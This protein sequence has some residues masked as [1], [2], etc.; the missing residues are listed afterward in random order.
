MSK[1][2]LEIADTSPCFFCT[3]DMLLNKSTCAYCGK[4]APIRLT[5]V[6]FM[7]AFFEGHIID[8]RAGGLVL[9]RHDNEEDIP[10]YSAVA[11]GV[12]QLC[13]VMQGGEYVINKEATAKHFARIEEINDY[14][15]STY[16]PIESI[17]ITNKTRVFNS[18][19]IKGNMAV[20]LDT[21]QYIIN[22]AATIK[23]YLELEEINNSVDHKVD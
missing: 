21:G 14:K 7:N 9:G 4:E 16:T 20:L 17:A 5:V 15:D 12:L 2:E 3:V 11:T 19:G 1:I 8:I 18:N 23:H 13:G 10:I 6:D 22:R